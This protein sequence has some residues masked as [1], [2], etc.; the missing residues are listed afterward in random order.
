MPY[1]SAAVVIF[2][3]LKLWFSSAGIENL[4]FILTPVDKIFGLITGSQSV[5]IQD[6]G[7]Y[8]ESFNI[9]IDKSCSGF[10][11]LLIC[12]L[13]F[14][15]L[16]T[17]YFSSPLHKILIFPVSLFFAWVLTIF[18]NASRVYLAVIALINTQKLLPNHQDLIHSA[19]NITVY[20]F[21]LLLTFIAVDYLFKN[22]KIYEKSN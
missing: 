19:I 4:S 15:F 17:G 1:F 6:S 11:F 14:V 10:N 12:F 13:S 18:V 16:I 7:Y 21:F 2:I 9:L 5:Y 3:L 20:L 8:H 22:R